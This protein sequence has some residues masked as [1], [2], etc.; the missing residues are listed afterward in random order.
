MVV[1]LKIISAT[2]V[3]DNTKLEARRQEIMEIKRFR[4]K[5]AAH[6]AFS[7]PRPEDNQAQELKSLVDLIST[8]HDGTSHTFRLGAMSVLVGGQRPDHEPQWQSTKCIQW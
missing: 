6:T 5:V 4:D 7:A 3:P 2:V 8:S 1:S